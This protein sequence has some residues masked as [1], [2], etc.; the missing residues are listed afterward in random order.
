MIA[1]EMRVMTTYVLPRG[2]S[3]MRWY[4]CIHSW[5]LWSDNTVTLGFCVIF[6]LLL[7]WLLFI[8][9]LLF[10]CCCCDDRLCW[11][12]SVC[13]NE[14]KWVRVRSSVCVECAWGC[15]RMYMVAVYY[16]I[17]I[18]HTRHK[19]MAQ[20]K[21]RSDRSNVSCCSSSSFSFLLLPY[22]LALSRISSSGTPSKRARQNREDK[23]GT[24]VGRNRTGFSRQ[25]GRQPAMYSL[26]QVS[27]SWSDYLV[28]ALSP[29]LFRFLLPWTVVT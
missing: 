25:S 21:E 9:I 14:C 10:F 17:I 27:V 7:L 12:S 11:F 23:N 8:L 29:R 3:K 13:W 22:R 5:V 6:L 4:V 18:T 1:T 16:L 28:L 15:T 2:T 19:R 26:K 20:G 24:P